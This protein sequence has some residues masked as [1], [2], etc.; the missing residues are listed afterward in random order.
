MSAEGLS[1]QPAET[2]RGFPDPVSDGSTP[3]F[4][5]NVLQTPEAL[6]VDPGVRHTGRTAATSNRRAERHTFSGHL[7][8][9]VP[10]QLLRLRPLTSA[11]GGADD[12]V[13]LPRCHVSAS[14]RPALRAEKALGGSPSSATMGNVGMETRVGIWVLTNSTTSSWVL[15]GKSTSR[16]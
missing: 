1:G 6:R 15:L 4:G 13:P 9:E 5:V 3:S 16:C 14:Q 2:P 10:S 12:E 8:S 11:V 7:V